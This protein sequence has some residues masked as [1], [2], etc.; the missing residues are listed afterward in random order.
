MHVA[1]YKIESYVAL[2]HHLHQTRHSYT[3]LWYRGFYG[4][5]GFAFRAIAHV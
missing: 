1:V 2:T 3:I 5:A 4:T